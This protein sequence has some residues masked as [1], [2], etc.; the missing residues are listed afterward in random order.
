MW[1]QWE[2]YDNDSKDLQGGSQI[3]EIEFEEEMVN[4]PK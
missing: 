1:I 2:D 4:D 3:F